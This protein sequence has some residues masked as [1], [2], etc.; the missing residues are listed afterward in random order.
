MK[1]FVGTKHLYALTAT[2]PDRRI[3]RRCMRAEQKQANL[4]LHNEV[5]GLMHD[6]LPGPV[7][8]ILKNLT[9]KK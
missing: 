3:S 9:Y 7:L 8:M 2:W 6:E 4:L 5:P 1:K